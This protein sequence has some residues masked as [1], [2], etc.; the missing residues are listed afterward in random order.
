MLQPLKTALVVPCNNNFRCIVRD[1]D[2]N[3]LLLECDE[4]IDEVLN[5]QSAE[6]DE[7]I[8][9]VLDD[10]ALEGTFLSFL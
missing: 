6:C 10:Q 8:Y 4:N 7:V 1:L 2:L 5:E 3:L 9:G